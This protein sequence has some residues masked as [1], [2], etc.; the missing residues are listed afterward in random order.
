ML[1]RIKM[2]KGI[3]TIDDSH[4]K[5]I[6]KLHKMKIPII[7]ISFGSPYLPDYSNLD[8]YICAYGYGSVSIKAATNCIFGRID[9]NGT[10]PVD[11]NN[12]FKMGHGIKLN[13]ITS[14]FNSI[15]D[16]N[17]DSSID[18]IK[19]AIND[20]IFPGAQLFVSKGN[21]II[22]DTGYGKTSYEDDAQDVT[23][24]T[25]YD[26]ASLTK[27]TSTVPVIMKLIEKKKLNLNFKLSE[28]YPE[29][30]SKDKENITIR[31]LLTHSSGLK[32]YIEYYKFD[33][34]DR[35]KIIDHIINLPL[36]YLPD[37]KTIY[38]DL[39]MILLLDIVEK[40]T[41]T[42]LDELSYKYIYK[43]LKMDNTFFN[44]DKSQH[45]KIA[46][47][48]KDDYF[49]MKLL[50]GVVH[51]ENS[52]ILGG[53]SGH[54]GLFSNSQDLGK[55]CKMLIDGGYYQ[56]R[57]IFQKA[58]IDNF[59]NRQNITKNSDYAL[60]WD[61]PSQNGRSSAGDY[62]SKSTF[63]HLGFT[64][65]SMWIDPENDIIVILLTNRVYPTRNKK[66]INKRMYNFRR[67][68]H[69]KLMSQ[70]LK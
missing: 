64:G 37:S 35:N 36:E 45:S 42:S 49:R 70:I 4:N 57:R 5:L 33:N 17:I 23:N 34:F 48:E 22:L 21:S 26:L 24:E 50:K 2:D 43:T 66:N 56:G 46:P 63:G 31:H 13:K 10:L 11:L 18:I 15:Q 55:Y 1:I 61:T 67:N 14:S 54:A 3:S 29:Y 62:F 51:D 60:G 65:T 19:E 41:Y 32:N 12:K 9:I 52:F 27:V 53:V 39:G 20:S 40:I 58:N 8:T 16:I 47:T 30:N 38:S 7:G 44:P 6:E 28:F 68:F 59:T 25:I 69:N